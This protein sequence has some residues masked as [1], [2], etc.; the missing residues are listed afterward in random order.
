MVASASLRWLM[1]VKRSSVLELVIVS[2]LG[3]GESLAS[4]ETTSDTWQ[5]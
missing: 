2:E 3:A 5:T 1:K 4:I